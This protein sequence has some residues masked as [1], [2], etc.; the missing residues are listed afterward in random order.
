M[1]CSSCGKQVEGNYNNCPYCGAP[2]MMVE[3]N[4]YQVP[5]QSDINRQR[6]NT[7][8]NQLK[9][10]ESS[11][12][13]AVLSFFF[14]LIGLILYFCWNKETPKKA[15]SCIKGAIVGFVVNLILVIVLP[16]IFTLFLGALVAGTNTCALSI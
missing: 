14:P 11:I 4:P 15:N 2:L 10:D 1:F 8:P 13:F 6:Y 5:P 16:L 12:G 7:V 9:E 3:D